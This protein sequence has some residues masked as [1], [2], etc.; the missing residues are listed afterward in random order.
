MASEIRLTP[1]FERAARRA[2]KKFGSLRTELDDLMAALV[3]NPR[4]GT[5]LDRKSVV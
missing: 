1:Q 4:L 5:P 3:R 2:L